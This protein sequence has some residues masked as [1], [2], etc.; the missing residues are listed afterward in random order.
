MKS[1]TKTAIAA[2]A[3]TFVLGGIGIA[4]AVAQPQP[5]PDT[6]FCAKIRAQNPGGICTPK[7]EYVTADKVYLPDGRVINRTTGS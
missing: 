5:R 7:G 4:V 3:S 1:I 2:L 6:E